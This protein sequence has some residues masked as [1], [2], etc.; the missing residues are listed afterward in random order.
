MVRLVP[1]E[2][3]LIEHRSLTLT[4]AAAVVN[5]GIMAFPGVDLLD[6]YG[7]IELLYFVAGNVHINVKIITPTADSVPIT[8]P[9]GNR[10]NST[11]RPEI[12]GAATFDDDLDLDVLMVPGG[13]AARD[14][15]MTYVDT[16]LQKAA[17]KAKHFVT[18]CTGALFAARA[19]LLDGK[20][21]TTNKGAWQLVTA[22]G[23]N[24]TWVAPARFVRDGN[25][26]SSSGVS[27]GIDLTFA[28]I[29][30]F[31][32]QDLH[33]RIT[34]FT[35]ILPRAH[36]DDPFT[37]IVGIPHQGQLNATDPVKC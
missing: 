1:S 31:Y 25:T 37:D 2:S 3:S 7:P 21:A 6:V 27:A 24:V 35:E 19:G 29:K 14:P 32:G 16:Y 13:A 23:D 5:W 11:F 12:V 10:F 30:E 17:P 28:M 20:R 4:P 34:V 33:D 8:P 22:Q 36:D 9:M 26:W 18:I 15:S